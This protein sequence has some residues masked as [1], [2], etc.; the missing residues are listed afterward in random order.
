MFTG[1]VRFDLLLPDDVRSL[2]AK[3]SV[4]RPIM[5]EIRRRFDVTV[6]EVGHVDLHRR[7]EIGVAIVS[8]EYAQCQRVLDTI[9]RHVANRPE[10]ELLSAHRQLHNDRSDEGHTW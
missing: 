4:V 7:S 6:A 9:E 8:A 10:I 3:R 5:A 1:T 2:K